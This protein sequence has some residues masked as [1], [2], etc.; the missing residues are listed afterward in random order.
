MIPSLFFEPSCAGLSTA[1][2]ALHCDDARL[3]VGVCLTPRDAFRIRQW[4]ARVDC[5]RLS[6]RY[7]TMPRMTFTDSQNPFRN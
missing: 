4:F 3:V 6:R 2:L 1:Y 5:A 7:G